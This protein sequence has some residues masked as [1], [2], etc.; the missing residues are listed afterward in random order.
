MLLPRSEL[1][2]T[3][4]QSCYNALCWFAGLLFALY[5]TT[6]LK[7][8]NIYPKQSSWRFHIFL[9]IT[10]CVNLEKNCMRYYVWC[11][12]WIQNEAKTGPQC[13][14]YV[15]ILMC[16]FFFLNIE[17]ALNCTNICFCF[18]V[19]P[20]AFILLRLGTYILLNLY[21]TSDYLI[22]HFHCK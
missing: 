2:F 7:I 14:G 3:Y 12:V 8:G 11:W 6:C 19:Y 9:Q 15:I 22:H 16:T 5:T 4:N 13:C 20:K 21:I 18:V 10:S 1:M 17:Q